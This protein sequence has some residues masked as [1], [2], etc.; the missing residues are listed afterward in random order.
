MNFLPIREWLY[1]VI[2]YNF[3]NKDNIFIFHFLFQLDPMSLKFKIEDYFIN[4][5]IPILINENGEHVSAV[6][7]KF[8]S[9]NFIFLYVESLLIQSLKDGD[10]MCPLLKYKMC[11]GIKSHDI[12]CR[13]DFLNV[14]AL[15]NP[16]LIT[17]T[18]AQMNLSNLPIIRFNNVNFYNADQN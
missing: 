8:R 4:I 7:E 11:N 10:R 9:N 6:P 3:K 2:N 1:H 5:G 17:K 14:I 18:L 13:N 16:C 12:W 15:N